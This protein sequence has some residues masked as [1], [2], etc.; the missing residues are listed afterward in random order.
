M[1]KQKAAPK[2][3]GYDEL[4][5]NRVA[6]FF[7]RIKMRW[8]LLLLLGLILALALLPALIVLFLKDASLASLTSAY[9]AGQS[10]LSSYQSSV[11]S[12][13]NLYAMFLVPCL[14]F[15][16]VPLSGVMRIIRQL[17]W[18]EGVFFGED[19]KDGVK[20]NGLSYAFLFLA[21]SLLYVLDSFI[22]NAGFSYPILQ[23]LPYG[24]SVVFFLPIALL[25]LDHVAVYKAT[26]KAALKNATVLFL[27]NFLGCYVGVIAF[28]APLLFLLIPSVVGQEIA[29]FLSALLY[30]PLTLLG[31]MLYGHFLFDRYINASNCPDLIDR[32]VYRL[33]KKGK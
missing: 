33:S 11:R 16:S 25:F 10:D 24:F 8:S 22:L 26:A 7:D 29:L 4:P 12:T 32:G 3:L 13:T 6:V 1:K 9:Q 2:D 31:W 5:H 17:S 30:L 19:F 23:A 14:V 28:L 27:K 15:F 18:G 21:M 20:Q